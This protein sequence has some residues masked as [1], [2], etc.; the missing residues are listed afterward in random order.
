MT[1]RFRAS[2]SST[3]NSTYSTTRCTAWWLC[4]RWAT[5]ADA[6]KFIHPGVSSVGIFPEGKR[7]VLR[8]AILARGVSSVLPLGGCGSVY[9]GMP[10]DGMLVLSQ[11]VDWKNA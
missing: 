9:A 5:L 8:D 10:H 1:P 11:L 6:L 7:A 3:M 4:A 2:L